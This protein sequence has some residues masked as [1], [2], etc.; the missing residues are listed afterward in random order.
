MWKEEKESQRL[1]PLFS[2]S[3]GET[4][5]EREERR[6]LLR[7]A[8]SDSSH[9]LFNGTLCIRWRQSSVLRCAEHPLAR[10]ELSLKGCQCL[11]HLSRV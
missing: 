10:E 5:N 6:G 2:R 4:P 11:A 1:D 8:L 9:T 7:I 3:V